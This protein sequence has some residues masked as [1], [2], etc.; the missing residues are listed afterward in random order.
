MKKICMIL[1]FAA[2]A[3]VVIAPLFFFGGQVS[4]DTTKVILNAATAVWF[5]AAL[6]WMGREK[7]AEG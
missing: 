7:K 6:F 5:V 1:S 3:A 2:L 4:L